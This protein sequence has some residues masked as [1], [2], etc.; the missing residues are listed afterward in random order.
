MEQHMLDFYM[1][2]HLNMHLFVT[3]CFGGH[4]CISVRRKGHMLYGYRQIH[5]HTLVFF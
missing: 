5:M 4:T 2:V 1:S 3:N